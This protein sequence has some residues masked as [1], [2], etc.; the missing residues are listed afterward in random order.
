MPILRRV[1]AAVASL[2]A[3]S[4]LTAAITVTL[5]PPDPASSY[6][7][8]P[9]R[10]TVEATA[11]IR[12]VFA[13]IGTNR[14]ALTRDISNSILW[15][16]Q[17]YIADLP[18]GEDTLAVTATDIDGE[19]A[20]ASVP[21]VRGSQPIITI[22]AP[23]PSTVA[24]TTVRVKATCTDDSGSCSSL[25][26]T[27][28]WPLPPIVSPNPSF[29]DEEMD[30]G[31][32]DRNPTIVVEG[33]D[34]LGNV[35][36]ASVTINAGTLG[37]LRPVA[38]AP[39]EVLDFDGSRLLYR[40][41]RIDKPDRLGIQTITG[42]A[43]EEIPIGTSSF[44]DRGWLTP[45][46]CLFLSHDT[47]TF[48]VQEWRDG[49]VRPPVI[50]ADGT[51]AGV[52][53]TMAW[54][55]SR[56]ALLARD[57]ETGVDRVIEAGEVVSADLGSDGR[58]VY[59]KH[60]GPS[61]PYVTYYFDGNQS[62][63]LCSNWKASRPRMDG[64]EA[65]YRVSAGSSWTAFYLYDGQTN[66][67][68][69]SMPA[70]QY[71]PRHDIRGGWGI[72]PFVDGQGWEHLLRRAPGQTT[73]TQFAPSIPAFRLP[74]IELAPS[75][76]LVYGP[77]AITPAGD[78]CVMTSRGAGN[79]QFL[80]A[81]RYVFIG[82]T[83]YRLAPPAIEFN[84]DPRSD[85]LWRNPTTGRMELWLMYGLQV[86]R[87]EHLPVVG[88]QWSTSTGD[89]NGDEQTDLL[90]RDATTGQV[91]IWFLSKG[92]IIGGRNLPNLPAEWESYVG[93]FDGDDHSDLLLRNTKTNQVS[94]WLCKDGRIVGG[95][96]L[97]DLSPAWQIR[98]GDF[99][100]DWKTDVL[101]RN[102]A[103]SDTTIWF[104]S[105]PRIIGGQGLPPVPAQYTV[106]VTDFN[107][108]HH[109]D[110][111]WHD[112]QSGDQTM[113]L[114]GSGRLYPSGGGTSL[115]FPA[116]HVPHFIDGDGDGDMDVLWRNDVTGTNTLL[117]VDAGF[118]GLSVL[119]TVQLPGKSG[120]TIGSM[121]N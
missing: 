44:V 101:L 30:L 59:E 66:T 82:N 4:T 48:M 12:S 69:Y 115:K 112:P 76:D 100:G 88:S 8:V 105:G 49:A 14:R 37:P 42:G 35:G 80:G 94:M 83:V 40:I 26:I 52:E 116:P 108:D 67:L 87:Y 99:N 29:L 61:G 120:W 7:G 36:M 62:M 103:Q 74:A 27:S 33:T 79:G 84:G 64:A 95:G 22:T 65:L 1:L 46:G 57:L 11:R 75:G 93:D 21:F 86:D 16:G 20:S 41:R 97:P 51:R 34:S 85:I 38:T 3:A 90:L 43:T 104:L 19:S 39:G 106:Y 73:V 78:A 56:D 58:A 24:W 107:R 72:I 113:W 98:T 18:F 81:R 89:F 114:L 117:V 68:L 71:E 63:L 91:T 54:I 118:P 31:Y 119:W 60:S 10:A 28:T 17:V 111:M 102:A 45:H 2:F 70:N 6:P 47:F 15:T 92:K 109:S 53:G 96:N 77:Y 110:V 32:L 50:V 13:T 55:A 5:T 121:Q 9:V 25:R 23:E